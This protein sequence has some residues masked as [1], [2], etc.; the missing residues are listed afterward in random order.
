METAETINV[1]A[2]SATAIILTA[3][4]GSSSSP[5]VSPAPTLPS[6]GMQ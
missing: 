6:I 3:C 4:G 2:L 1:Q 5:V